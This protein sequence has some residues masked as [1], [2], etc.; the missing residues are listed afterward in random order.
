MSEVTD[1]YHFLPLTDHLLTSGQPS[2]SQFEPV[3]GSGVETVINLALDT[4]DHALPDE[5]EIVENL[6]MEYVHIPVLW[7]A[8]AR[9]DLDRFMDA[10]DARQGK[11]L[12]VHCAANMRVSAFVALYRVLR[13]GWDWE[14]AAV[15]VRRIWDPDQ[16]PVWREFIQSSL[17]DE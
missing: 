4:S 6:G 15:D 7:E 5:A 1:I 10:M 8:P 9:A 13:Q 11:K 3:A 14:K 12:L 2:R 16:N 17:Q